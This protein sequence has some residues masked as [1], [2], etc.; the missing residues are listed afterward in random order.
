MD[1]LSFPDGT[2]SNEV[3]KAAKLA[4]YKKLLSVNGKMN[5]HKE[6]DELRSRL[7]INPHI[8]LNNQ[9]EAVQKG[10]Y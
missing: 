7:V 3:L 9:M 4:G 6:S 5:D 1:A 2:F 10:K 8:S